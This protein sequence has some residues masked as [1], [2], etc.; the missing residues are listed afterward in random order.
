MKRPSS[1]WFFCRGLARLFRQ[2]LR[3]PS[4]L[5]HQR[6]YPLRIHILAGILALDQ[7]V[8]PGGHRQAHPI[9][10]TRLVIPFLV[11]L[12]EI[13]IDRLGLGIT[14]RLIFSRLEIQATHPQDVVDALHRA[15]GR[16][17]PVAVKNGGH[18]LQAGQDRTGLLIPAQDQFAGFGAA[19][20]R[21]A[22][23]A[24]QCHSSSCWGS[25]S[26]CHRVTPEGLQPE[27][28][29]LERSSSFSPLPARSLF[30]CGSSLSRLYMAS[31]KSSADGS[32]PRRVPSFF[33]CSTVS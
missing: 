1:A 20:L 29:T 30:A 7:H 6:E 13:V 14:C 10:Q 25:R 22:S 8:G 33:H 11:T 32:P 2:R 27:R 9:G 23:S 31:A 15:G 4:H 17:P 28:I 16:R 26:V 3:F 21:P 18:V 24:R 19:E 12:E 5:R